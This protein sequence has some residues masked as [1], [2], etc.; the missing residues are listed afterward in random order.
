MAKQRIQPA[1]LEDPQR[2]S[3]GWKAGNTVYLAGAIG[4]NDDGSLSPDIKVQTRRAWEKLSKVM[5]EAGGS[6]RDIVKVTVFLT[7]M[8]Y[9]HGQ[10]EVR[11]ELFPGDKPASTLVQCVALAIPGA[12]IEIEGIAILDA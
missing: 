2:Y 7:D 11:A 9:Q 10:G 3:L 12:L 4:T 5:E 8:R 6:L 1:T